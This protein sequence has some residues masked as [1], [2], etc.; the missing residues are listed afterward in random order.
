MKERFYFFD[1]EGDFQEYKLHIDWRK[2]H[3]YATGKYFYNL[4]L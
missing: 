3:L 4:N 2:E 1:V